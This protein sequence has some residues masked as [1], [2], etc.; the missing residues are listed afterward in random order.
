MKDEPEQE[1]LGGTDLL[2][3]YIRKF[4]NPLRSQ[5]FSVM[6]EIIQAFKVIHCEDSKITTA[7]AVTGVSF[8]ESLSFFVT[9]S[10]ETVSVST[11]DDIFALDSSRM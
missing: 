6:H 3:M 7:A 5:L 1:Q 8:E 2:L 11:I 10:T 4:E 9:G